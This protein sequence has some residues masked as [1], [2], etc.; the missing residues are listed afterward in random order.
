MT[1]EDHRVVG[2][3]HPRAGRRR[4]PRDA[5]VERADAEQ[6]GDA[7]PRR[8]PSAR[9][10]RPSGARQTSSTPPA[11]APRRTRRRGVRPRHSGRAA[12]SGSIG[13]HGG[14]VCRCSAS[15]STSAP[16][17][18]DTDA[19]CPV[20]WPANAPGR[21]C[22]P[23][24]P[25]RC[26]RRCPRLTEAIIAA[27]AASIPEYK[28]PI[29]GAFGQGLRLGVEEA[30]ERFVR[31]IEEPGPARRGVAGLPRAGP[32]RDARRAQPRRAAGRL[33]ARRAHRLAPPRR[34]GRGRRLARPRRCPTLAEAI[35]AYIDELAGA[36]GR[37][38]RRGAVGRRRRARPPPRARCSTCCWPTTTP[39][40][41]ARRS[42]R[43]RARRLAAAAHA[44]RGRAAP[45]R[46]RRLDRPPRRR[47]RARRAHAGGPCALVPDPAGPGRADLLAGGA[48]RPAARRSAPPSSRCAPAASLRPRA[49]PAARW[50]GRP[51]A[52]LRVDDH[53]AAARARRRPRAAR[54]RSP[55]GG[56]PRWTTARRPRARAWSET[57]LA[58]LEQQGSAPAVARALHVHPQTVRYRLARLREAL[59][60]QLD[61][62]QARFELQLAL[63]ARALGRRRS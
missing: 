1:Q 37:G 9:R 14:H 27:I 34:G 19:K 42:S 62:P 16:R 23:A 15:G 29:E 28:R 39:P 43:G 35:F 38:L 18:C 21:T 46:R 31:L 52:P 26:A 4:A 55:S 49:A 3:A 50:R 17:F 59:G 36:V 45:R 13:R 47:R 33:P 20:S 53:L 56:W 44:G 57:L 25:R 5:V 60:D 2:A 40:S 61:D 48:G 6:P 30:L 12:T 63:R 24:S 7:T 54:P 32:R 58:W 10:A 11:S 22:R 8:S 41:T 51:T